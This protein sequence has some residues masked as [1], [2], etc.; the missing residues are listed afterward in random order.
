MSVPADLH[1]TLSPSE[2]DEKISGNEPFREAVGSLV[3][4]AAVSRPDIAYA[5]NSVSK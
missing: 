1:V 2:I 4:L 3:F 5:V